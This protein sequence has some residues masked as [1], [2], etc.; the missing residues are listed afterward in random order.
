MDQSLRLY[1]A[2]PEAALRAGDMFMRM[3]KFEKAEEVLNDFAE[4]DPTNK[5]RIN[6]EISLQKLRELDEIRKDLEKDNQVKITGNTSLQLMQIYAQFEMTSKQL[7][8]ADLLLDLPNLHVDFYIHL[9]AFMQRN[10]N[11]EYYQKAVEKWAEKDPQDARAQIDLAVIALSED[12]Y[13]EMANHLVRAVQLDPENTRAQLA[14]D[15]RFVDVRDWKQFQRL[16][17]P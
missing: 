13:V 17:N 6:F 3:T 14:G 4:H 10:K 2:N 9:A 8:M 11:R 7:L 16:I 15:I 1:P 5:Q 12:R